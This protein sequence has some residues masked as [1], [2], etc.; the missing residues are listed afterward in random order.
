MNWRNFFTIVIFI[1]SV[2]GIFVVVEL[3]AWL[4]EKYFHIHLK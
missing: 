3:L 1:L 4:L 2:A